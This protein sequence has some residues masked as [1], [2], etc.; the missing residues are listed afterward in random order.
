MGEFLEFPKTVY[1]VADGK[2]ETQIVD[3]TQ[4]QS[5]AEVE[6][7]TADLASLC[8]AD[9]ELKPIEPAKKGKGE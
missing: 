1:R 5:V 8:D 3:S 9:G 6:G 7:F 4:T 2:L